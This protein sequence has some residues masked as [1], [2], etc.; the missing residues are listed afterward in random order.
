MELP[1]AA[2]GERDDVM[3]LFRRAFKKTPHVARGLADALLVL[4]QRDAH[5]AF[6]ALAEP[7][8]GETATSAFSTRSLENSTLPSVW[9][10]SGIGDQANIDARGDGIC[11]P[12]RPKLSTSTSRRRLY[13]SRISRMQSSGPLSAAVAAT[14]TGV[15]A[16]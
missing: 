11:Q 1:S 8:P 9:K 14:C 7:G 12:A 3:Q 6:A 4:N 16:P 2:R 10:G 5:I 15:N 13:V